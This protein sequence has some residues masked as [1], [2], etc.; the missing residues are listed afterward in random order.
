M[1]R[2]RIG[3]PKGEPL[4]RHG[5]GWLSGGW[6]TIGT[7]GAPDGLGRGEGEE[8]REAEEAQGSLPWATHGSADVVR[9]RGTGSE[10]GKPSVSGAWVRNIS[11]VE[12]ASMGSPIWY[13]SR[14][15]EKDSQ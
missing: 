14:K 15:C 11:M 1:K 12:R 4:E 10:S 3:E 13:R 8:R 2:P 7:T 6:E 9:L 5:S